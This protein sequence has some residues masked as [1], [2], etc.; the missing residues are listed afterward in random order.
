MI[1]LWVPWS[2]LARAPRRPGLSPGSWPTTRLCLTT[3]SN[4]SGGRTG[5][6]GPGFRD[7][8]SV[9]LRRQEW[10]DRPLK[11]LGSSGG[12]WVP[13]HT[14][15]IPSVGWRLVGLAKKIQPAGSVVHIG[16]ADRCNIV[17]NEQ[18]FLMEKAVWALVTQYNKRVLLRKYNCMLIILSMVT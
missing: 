6:A 5:R 2:L 13:N 11:T 14:M 1:M 12:W 15:T 18:H 9:M 3:R 7:G 4:P 16:C 17:I 8:M 10:G